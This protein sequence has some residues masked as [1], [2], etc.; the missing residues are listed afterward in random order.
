[1]YEAY[2]LFAK[3]TSLRLKEGGMIMNYHPKIVAFKHELS[4]VRE[5]INHRPRS[6]FRVDLQ[7]VVQTDTSTITKSAI[8]R[9]DGSKIFMIEMKA[10]QKAYTIRADE[11][12]LS[13]D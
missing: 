2:D 3:F 8:K 4:K 12:K 9:D 11:I 6:V 1:M 5:S 13:F 7:I 10:Y